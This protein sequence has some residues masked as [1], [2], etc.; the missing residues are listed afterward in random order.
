MRTLSPQLTTNSHGN[1][2]QVYVNAMT[3]NVWGK[4]RM[5]SQ[6]DL[7]LDNVTG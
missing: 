7:A 2:K 4:L 6:L 1:G 3:Q 5:T